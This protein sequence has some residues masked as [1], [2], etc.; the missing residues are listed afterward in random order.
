MSQFYQLWIHCFISKNFKTQLYKFTYFDERYNFIV[1]SLMKNEKKEINEEE[2]ITILHSLQSGL[3]P[4]DQGVFTPSCKPN[5]PC[6]SL[7]GNPLS[8]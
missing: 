5:Y 4:Q 1:E 6:V 8:R 7:I 2:G 3:L